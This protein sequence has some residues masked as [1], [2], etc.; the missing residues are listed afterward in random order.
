M[1]TRSRSRKKTADE[2]YFPIRIRVR[3][4]E[5]GLGRRLDEMT[6]WLD[7]NAGRGRWGWN[8]DC[9]LST[10]SRDAASIYL[11]DPGLVAPMIRAFDL[12]LAVADADLCGRGSFYNFRPVEHIT[13]A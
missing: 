12:E 1:T 9:V 2:N 7:E 8:A 4:P 11:M 3:V 5:E 6:L 13:P 10:K